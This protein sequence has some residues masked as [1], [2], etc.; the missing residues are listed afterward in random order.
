MDMGE[1]ARDEVGKEEM[2]KVAGDVKALQ[3]QGEMEEE[4]AAKE[5]WEMVAKED[6]ERVGRVREVA[7]A[8]VVAKVVAAWVKE[9]VVKGEEEGGWAGTWVM[10]VAE[11]VEEGEAVAGEREDKAA[12]LRRLGGS[13]QW[14][15]GK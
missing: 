15:S 1:G 14:Y 4:G 9:G 10:G 11:G 6:T 8:A 5:D 12:Q 3:G 13:L 7:V 2:V